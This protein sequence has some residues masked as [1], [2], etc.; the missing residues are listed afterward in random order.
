MADL[1]ADT[2]VRG[3]NGRYTATLSDDWEVW[4]P[5]GGYLSSVAL[6]AAGAH[7]S[8]PRPASYNGH[9]LNVASFGD[10]EIDVRTLRS[11]RRAE[12]LHVSMRQGDVA[13]LEALVWLTRERDGLVHDVGVM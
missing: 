8:L 6:R 10:V 5:N 2:T 7:G 9:F 11:S 3:S 13:I 1:Q 4:G 12:S